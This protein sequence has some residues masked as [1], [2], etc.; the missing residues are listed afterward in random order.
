MSGTFFSRRNR[1]CLTEGPAGPA[2]EKV[3]ASAGAAEREAA[4]YRLLS[5]GGP[6]TAALLG[7][8]EN[9]LRLS[10]LEGEDYLALLERQER[11][12]FSPE[13]WD[14]L[15]EW[16]AAFHRVTGLVQ[17]DVNLR[18][19]LWH[20]GAAAGLDFEDCEAGNP[21]WMATRLAAYVLLYD[22]PDT[23][24]KRRA[25]AWIQSRA[26][27]LFSC[28]EGEFADGLAREREALCR[29]RQNRG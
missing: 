15:L 8:E 5:Q 9:R 21:L 20:D 25:A 28:S 16:L 7:Q 18:N 26:M 10:F 3:F 1:V 4:V 12:G 23:E 22:P 11:E 19:F 17:R 27:E 2:V 24:T 6:K 14:R 29:Q 13:P